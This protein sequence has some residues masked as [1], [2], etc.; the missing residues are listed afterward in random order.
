[1]SAN[2][3]NDGVAVLYFGCIDVAGHCLFHPTDSECRRPDLITA[4]PW[5][6]SIDGAVFVGS[7]YV[8]REGYIHSVKR[9]GWTAVGWAD[10]SID[11][12]P[13]SHSTFLAKGDFTNEELIALARA[14]WPKVFSRFKF[15]KL[16]R[17]HAT[18]WELV[19]T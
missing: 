3:T 7:K 11:Q 15:P 2:T 12:R 19:T 1:M 16:Y 5:R 14:Q 17:Q 10:N 13:A 4:I 8:Y 6:Y 18:G 9:D